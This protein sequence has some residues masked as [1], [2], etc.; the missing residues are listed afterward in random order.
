[1]FDARR[2]EKRFESPPRWPYNRAMHP[3]LPPAGVG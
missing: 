3:I 1:M 2:R